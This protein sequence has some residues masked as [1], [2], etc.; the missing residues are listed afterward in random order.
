MIGKGLFALLIWF[1][2]NGTELLFSQN[3]RIDGYYGLWYSQAGPRDSSFRFSGAA[4]T[5]ASRHR[6]VAI[7]SPEAKKTYFVYG[8]TTSPSE[9]HLLIMISYYDHRLR[10][11]PRPVVVCDKMGV[12]EPFDNASLSIDFQGFIRVFVSGRNRTRPGQIYKSVKPYSIDSFEIVAE[13]EMIY[14]QPWRTGDGEL[15]LL[16]SRIAKSEEL[17]FEKSRDGMTWEGRKNLS[18]FGG[19]LQVSAMKGDK[20]VTAFN[21]MPENNRDRRTNLYILQSVNK[22]ESWETAAGDKIEIPLKSADN[23]ALIFDFEAEGK[24]VYLCDINFDKNT[25]PVVL[26][27]ISTE[28]RPGPSG[29]PREWCIIHL[30][31][32]V[33]RVTKVC[34]SMHN[35]DKGSLYISDDEWRIIGPSE[36][37]PQKYGTGGEI[38]AWVSNDEGMTWRKMADLTSGSM[39]NHSFVRRPVNAN[40][41]FYAF[42]ADGDADKFSPSRLYYT[43]ESCEKVWMMPESI[44]GEMTKARRI[45]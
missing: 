10:S 12:R 42:W 22:G 26:A 25:N 23:E 8:G 34:E 2:F 39:Y 33:W 44:K 41:R 17:I 7:Y 3:Q 11:F 1:V 5:F 6:P 45:R 14:P 13:K 43:D 27:L 18:G 4:A 37:G 21:Y 20:I 35:F 40:K 38:A 9:R 15:M 31:S 30:K 32:G 36:P 24:F 28:T 16:Y 19:H 29:K